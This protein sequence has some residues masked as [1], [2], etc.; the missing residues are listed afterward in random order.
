MPGPP[1]MTSASAGTDRCAGFVDRRHQ[2]GPVGAERAARELLDRQRKVRDA[3]IVRPQQL[4]KTRDPGLV[5]QAL[6]AFTASARGTVNLLELAITTVQ[7]GPYAVH[8][9]PPTPPR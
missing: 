3:Q 8:H 4:K 1:S 5:Q 2:Q 6:A 9:I 7:P